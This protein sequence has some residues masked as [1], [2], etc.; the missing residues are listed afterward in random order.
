MAYLSID[1]ITITY[2]GDEKAVAEL[3]KAL[4]DGGSEAVKKALAYIESAKGSID[5]EANAITM[6][7]DG[8][9]IESPYAF[10]ALVD[11]FRDVTFIFDLRFE[12]DA[13]GQL[14]CGRY[15]CVFEN[16]EKVF[17]A[18]NWL[19]Y[20]Q[21]MNDW[22]E[23]L[24]MDFDFYFG[25]EEEAKRDIAKCLLVEQGEEPSE[26]SEEDVENYLNGHH[27]EY[28][29]DRIPII[30][31]DDGAKE[32]TIEDHDFLYW[33]AILND[34]YIY[35]GELY[36]YDGYLACKEEG[37]LPELRAESRWSMLSDKKRWQNSI[38]EGDGTSDD[39][40]E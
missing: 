38:A 23:H 33:S 32:I 11:T 10:A 36:G 14:G 15:Y 35:D 37:N 2:E 31:G 27:I 40:G 13:A 25:D 16:G 1:D 4:K 3:E 30:H 7:T 8:L 12:A 18:H 6:H 5:Y 34:D 39:D 28:Y 19:E 20:H 21:F 26:I 9:D 22:A 17:D 24:G 29:G